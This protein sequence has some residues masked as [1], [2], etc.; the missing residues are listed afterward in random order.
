M[1]GHLAPLPHTKN[2]T[3]YSDNYWKRNNFK[4][5]SMRVR[6]ATMHNSEE[7][8]CRFVDQEKV[9]YK[10]ARF[11]CYRFVVDFHAIDLL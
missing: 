8:L 9:V 3:L 5:V 11:S 1:V 10:L 2:S 4:A 6:R 7:T